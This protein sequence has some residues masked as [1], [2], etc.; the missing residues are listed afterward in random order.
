[1][2]S[3]NL[4]YAQIQS[5]LFQAQSANATLLKVIKQDPAFEELRGTLS[6][7]SNIIVS[8]KVQGNSQ[9]GALLSHLEQWRDVF[10]TGPISP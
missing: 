1:M 5:Q 2:M 10:L 6:D 3:M 4:D 7:L 9:L 8:K